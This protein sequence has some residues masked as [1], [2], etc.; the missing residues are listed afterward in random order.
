MFLKLLDRAIARRHP[1]KSR[2]D[3]KAEVVA[4]HDAM[5]HELAKRYARGNVNIKRGAFLTRDDLDARRKK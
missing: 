3:I 5:G 1:P 4:R 2:E